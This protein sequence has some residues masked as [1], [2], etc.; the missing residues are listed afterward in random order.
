MKKKADVQVKNNLVIY[1][2][3][4]G[5]LELKGDFV[6]ETVWATQVQ[7]AEVFRIDR[8]VV[9]KHIKNIYKE[10]ELKEKPTSAKIAQVQNE[11]NRVVVREVEHYNLDV[12]LSVGYRV[13]SK[14]ATLFRQ[15]ATKTLREHLI[16]GYTFNKKVVL[17]NYDQFIKNVSDIQALL[18]SNTVL[19]PKNILEL[20]KEYASTWAKLDAYDRDELKQT[21]A[22]KKK[23]KVSAQELHDAILLLRTELI[24]KGE[25]TDIFAHER[26]KGNV[27]GILGNIMQS[28][29]G[30]EVYPT[31]EEKAAHL[32]YF[33]VKNH[34]F[35][36]GNKRS[37]AFTFIWFLRKSGVKGVVNINPSGLTAL[38]LLIAESNPLHKEKIIALIV[39]LLQV[40]KK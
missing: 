16:K 7:I 17:K 29:G 40:N 13:N 39:E 1:Q 23:I 28:F 2:T 34:P 36:D 5:S 24:T 14:T 37:G 35:T 10:G 9:T 38:T 6:H 18:P 31:L 3:K 30:N 26:T 21:G 22:T 27:E 32:L 12:I 25:A 20:V 15:W 33:M 11:G 4:S 8:S 19:D